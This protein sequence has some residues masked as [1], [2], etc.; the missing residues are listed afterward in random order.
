MTRRGD[1]RDENPIFDFAIVGSGVSG[2]RLAYELTAAG[3]KCVLLEAGREFSAKTFP[4]HEIDYSTQMFWGGGLEVTTDGRLG[5]LRAKVL[6]GT[7]IVNQALLDRFDALAFDDWRARSGVGFLNP[8]DMT[9]HYDV[10]EKS[11][12]VSAIPVEHYN[13]NTHTFTKAFNKLGYGW[14][15]LTRAQSDCKLDH[16]SDC[17]ACLGGCPRDSKQSSLV[18][19]IRWARERGL[20]VESEFE[21]HHLDYAPGKITIHGK[22]RGVAAEVTA[23]RVVLAAGSLGNSAILLRT[24]LGGKLPALGT[25]FACHPQYMSYAMFDE[26]V[27]AHKGAFQ[28]VKSDDQRF[29]KLGLKFENVF[30]PPIGTAMLVPGFGA[31]H[32]R[33]MRNYRYLAS[34]EVAVR[35]D[36]KGRITVDKNDR[37]RVDKTL[38]SDDR[39]KAKQGLKLVRELFEAAGAKEVITCDQAFGLHLMGGCA[40][41]TSGA[42]SVV[43]PEFQVH[44]HPGLYAADSSIFPSA[45]GINP[46]FTIMALSHRAAREI[47]KG[48]G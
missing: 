5:L 17:I 35:D 44:D 31:A 28:A 34:M 32:Q 22:Q 2:G 46:S 16:G 38:T 24:G 4:R 18:T 15:P 39:A 26:P 10:C 36:A 3:A 7:S 45:P 20:S 47:L 19:T 37:V 27:D 1:S 33:V 13:R 41:G 6:G 48:R 42:T 12:K 14:K 30:A 8:N 23:A 43:N 25:G 40:I 11:I 29:R 21:A 9:P